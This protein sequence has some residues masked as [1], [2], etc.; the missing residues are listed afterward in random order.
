MDYL[1]LK[2][3][4]IW[5]LNTASLIIPSLCAVWPVSGFTYCSIFIKLILFLNFS[6]WILLVTF[7]VFSTARI[8]IKYFEFSS[9]ISSFPADFH[10]VLFIREINWKIT[11]QEKNI[12]NSTVDPSGLWT[13]PLFAL[14]LQL[15]RSRFLKICL[16]IQIFGN[17][18][19][20]DNILGFQ[21]DLVLKS[22]SHRWRSQPKWSRTA[23]LQAYSL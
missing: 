5:Y 16:K 17:D 13:V 11:E 10:F 22:S 4:H 21:T 6:A 8:E 2:L 20:I 12:W 9:V 15:A 19:G 23:P 3:I 14:F 1:W 7:F 18:G